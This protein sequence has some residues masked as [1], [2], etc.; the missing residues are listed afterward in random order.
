[1]YKLTEN[2]SVIRLEDG[3]LIP[4]DLSNSDYAAYL[5]WLAEGNTPDPYVPPP[6]P[7][8][9]SLS[10]KQARLAL[11]QAGYLDAVEAGIASMDKPAQIIWEFASTVE[12]SDPLVA[13]MASVLNL[14][15]EDLDD[16]Y[17]LGST[18]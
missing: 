5:V 14:T 3:A 4:C 17:T 1:M 18:L 15:S 13:A 8:P 2:T 12:R 11:Y 9:T 7:I 6:A 10:I 16:L